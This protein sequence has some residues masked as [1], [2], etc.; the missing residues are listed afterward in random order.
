VACKPFLNSFPY[1]YLFLP[2]STKTVY[3]FIVT[4]SL[5]SSKPTCLCFCI[6]VT[7]SLFGQLPPPIETSQLLLNF[8]LFELVRLIFIE[9]PFW[10]AASFRVWP[11]NLMQISC[12]LPLSLFFADKLTKCWPDHTQ[13]FKKKLGKENKNNLEAVDAVARIAGWVNNLEKWN[14]HRANWSS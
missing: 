1:I 2:S 8:P 7:S 6:F 3:K 12:S 11:S 10:V 5:Y 9:L 4:G 14:L 13:K